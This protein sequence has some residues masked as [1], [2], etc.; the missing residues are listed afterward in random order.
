MAAGWLVPYLLGIAWARGAFRGW[1]IP[2]L[3]LAGGTAA[4]AALVLW[5]GYPASMVGVNGA[6][7][8]N[9]NPPT[10]A[11]V[12]FG[13][14][15]VGLALLLR[16]PL[17]RWMRRP[18]AWAAVATANLSAMTLFLWSQT[19]FLIVTMAGLLAGRLPGLHTAPTT[20]V[21]IAER[22]AWLPAFAAALAVLWV[23]FRRFERAPRPKRRGRAGDGP[24]PEGVLA[25]RPDGQ[26]A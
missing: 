18:L 24:R 23:V 11:V 9:L 20:P 13:V 3:M 4:T 1:K 8:S 17:A 16:E 26:S 10:L 7:I 14:A 12:T 15:Q 25:S 19:A 5:A 2:A 22:I 21:W 6:K